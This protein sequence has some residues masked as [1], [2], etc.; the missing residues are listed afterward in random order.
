M[1]V[2]FIGWPGVLTYSPLYSQEIGLNFGGSFFLAFGVGL[3]LAQLITKVI[4]EK[5][6]S[7][8]INSLAIVLVICGH[9]VIGLTHNQT[10]FLIGAV[11]IGMGYALSF[12]IF[13]KLTFDLVIPERRGRCSGTLFIVEDLGATIGIY[14]Y[15]FIAESTGTFAN[16]YLMAAGVSVVSLLV[17]CLAALPDYLRKQSSQVN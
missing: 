13:T 7:I 16:A 9:G 12:S 3:V 14:T 17:L 8:F 6:K 11:I 4:L 5:S 10:G 2:L 15:S 1:G